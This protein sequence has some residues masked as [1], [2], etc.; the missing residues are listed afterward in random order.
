MLQAYNLVIHKRSHTAAIQ[1]CCLTIHRRVHAS[2][3]PYK[4]GEC[5]AGFLDSSCLLRHTRIHTGEKPYTCEVCNKSFSQSSSLKM[6]GHIHTTTNK[7]NGNT[8]HKNK[9]TPQPTA[10]E[11]AKDACGSSAT[12]TPRG[13]KSV[14]EL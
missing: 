3:R 10:P 9:P 7:N 13:E 1:L 14:I 4:C 6:H 11:Q 12:V 2:E 8:P 5:G